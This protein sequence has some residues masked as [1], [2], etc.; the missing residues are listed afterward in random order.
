MLQKNIDKI[1]DQQMIFLPI[2]MLQKKIYWQHFLSTNDL[3]QCL[4]KFDQ[5]MTFLSV[6]QSSINTWPSSVS[7][8]FN[9]DRHW[10]RSSVDPFVDRTLIDTEEG[11]LL[12]ENVV[13]IFFFVTSL[14]VS[15][16]NLLDLYIHTLYIYIYIDIYIR[17]N[18]FIGSG[19][20]RVV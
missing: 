3:P 18:P 12:I 9:F 16:H 8:K 2:K 1:F 13:N 17:L 15:L 4:S 7:I 6:Y 11:H 14:S 20:G 5:Q 19:C 10:G